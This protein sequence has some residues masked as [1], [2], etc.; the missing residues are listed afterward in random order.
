MNKILLTGQIATAPRVCRYPDGAVAHFTLRTRIT[1][2][3]ERSPLRQERTDSHPVVAY[4][5]A[6]L[7]CTLVGT[8]EQIGVEGWL[9]AV[10]EEVE[11]ET[12]T[13]VEV[14]ATDIHF[15]ELKLYQE[16]PLYNELG[17]ENCES[18][19][20]YRWW[21]EE[22][23]G[24][25][26][27]PPDPRTADTNLVRL[28]G[29]LVVDP[30]L[31]EDKGDIVAVLYVATRVLSADR[32]GQLQERRKLAHVVA[33]GELARVCRTLKKYDRLAVEGW[34]RSWTVQDERGDTPR[35]D[36]VASR[37]ERQVITGLLQSEERES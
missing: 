18:Q 6:A 26:E 2:Y 8:G 11:G 28:N 33:H 15:L 22:D 10:A 17:E 29:P 20:E 37:I 32:Q 25:T 27:E 16:E 23:P 14:V 12:R 36:I 30:E 5:S 35:V 9:R 34:L 1:Y 19:R 3:D 24:T 13:R 21:T 4:G 7:A 31:F